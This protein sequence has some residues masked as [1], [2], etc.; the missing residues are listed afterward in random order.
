M[1]REQPG[2]F[3]L[4]WTVSFLVAFFFGYAVRKLASGPDDGYPEALD[5]DPIEMAFLAGGWKGALEAAVNLLIAHKAIHVDEDLVLRRSAHLPDSRHPLEEHVYEMLGD[6][7]LTFSALHKWKPSWVATMRRRM[8][9]MGLWRSRSRLRSV[10]FILASLPSFAVLAWGVAQIES[11]PVPAATNLAVA[12]VFA[13]NFV[14]SWRRVPLTRR[15]EAA[16]LALKTA[17]AELRP[18]LGEKL[19][20]AMKPRDAA[21]AAG[22]FGA[23]LVPGVNESW[24]RWVDREDASEPPLFSWLDLDTDESDSDG[25]DDD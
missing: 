11:N 24:F 22:L 17:H 19:S 2:L 1:A 8:V 10:V 6:D 16:V 7:G 15:G 18:G 25:G 3:L 4:I 14:A 5:F 12:F 23:M 13:W 9:R 21:I 20:E